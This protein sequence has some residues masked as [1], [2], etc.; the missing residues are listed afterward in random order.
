MHADGR[1]LAIALSVSVICTLFWLQ[2]ID[3][4]GRRTRLL[5]AVDSVTQSPCS[6][7]PRATAQGHPTPVSLAADK[8]RAGLGYG[9][10]RSGLES[11]A[12]GEG[13]YGSDECKGWERGQTEGRY[14][15]QRF[16]ETDAEETLQRRL[17]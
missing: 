14:Q 5:L 7:C 16:A 11:S 15:C 9:S 6:L 3:P 17:V 2:V 12:T 4:G 10:V 13:M 8:F 1:Q